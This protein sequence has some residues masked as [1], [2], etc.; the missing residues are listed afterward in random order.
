MKTKQ[1]F[2]VALVVATLMSVQNINAQ[3]AIKERPTEDNTDVT[4]WIVNPNFDNNDLE[5]WSGYSDVN[6]VSNGYFALQSTPWDIKTF[7]L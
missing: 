4:A 2:Y 7:N 3:D 5:G 1:L 6:T